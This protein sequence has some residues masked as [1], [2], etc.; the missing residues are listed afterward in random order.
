MA[1]LRPPIPWRAQACRERGSLV[2]QLQAL[3]HQDRFYT[4]R[5]V[6]LADRM[7]GLQEI[8]VAGR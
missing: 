7:H 3:T 4:S 2:E 6:T 8:M 5:R 1:T